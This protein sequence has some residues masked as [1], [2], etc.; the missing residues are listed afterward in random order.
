MGYGLA[1]TPY[2]TNLF[3]NSSSSNPVLD[4]D[5]Q[6]FITAAAITN[7][8]QQNAINNLVIGLKADGLWSQ[9]TAIYPFVGGTASQHKY[10]LKDPRDLNAAY[11]LTFFGGWTHDSRGITGNGT[12]TYADTYFAGTVS[13]V[14]VYTPTGYA[15]NLSFGYNETIGYCDSEGCSDSPGLQISL[16]TTGGQFSG[17]AYEYLPGYYGAGHGQVGYITGSNVGYKNGR[18]IST[19]PIGGGPIL[20]R[21]TMPIGGMRYVTVDGN[22][23]TVIASDVSNYTNATQSFAYFANTILDDAETANLYTRIQAFQ[24]TLNRQVADLPASDADAYAFLNNRLILDPVNSLTQINAVNNLA[25]SLKSENL[26]NK[27]T[28]IFPIV[29]DTINLL[30]WTEDFQVGNWV[31]TSGVTVTA[32][33]STAPNGNNNA[34]TIVIPNNGSISQAFTSATSQAHTFSIYLR[35][36]SNLTV[37]IGFDNVSVLTTCNVTTSW[38]R[39]TITHTFIGTTNPQIYNDSGSSVTLIAWGA[40]AQL[41]S[42]ATTYQSIGSTPTDKIRSQFGVSLKYHQTNSPMQQ[43]IPELNNTFALTGITSNGINGFIRLGNTGISTILTAGN[44]HI[45]AYSRSAITPATN[46]ALWGVTTTSPT[47]ANALAR[48]TPT[49]FTVQS[50]MGGTS[51]QTS[52]F[53]NTQGLVMASITGYGANLNNIY[54]NGVL[55]ASSTAPN[56]SPIP[57]STLSFNA[58]NNNFTTINHASFEIAFISVG[59]GLTPAEAATFYNIVNTY[60]TA[61]SRNV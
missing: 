38:Q 46:L 52:S 40:M 48:F 17:N 43:I 7:S 5:A 16:F 28:A 14:G 47:N 8:T 29:S 55:K 35:A 58:Y 6:I 3:L 24:T 10:N 36:A 54:Q 51:I 49:P 2:N 53:T 20:F 60:Q 57:T 25:I 21:D 9:M 27:I 11:R 39:F 33:N 15:A 50:A 31:R 37:K 4:P 34:D 45:S 61:L 44:A 19:S 30:S 41:G 13:A 22:T 1:Y 12:N 18:R 26:W 32:N 56:P 59:Q 42:T 23:N